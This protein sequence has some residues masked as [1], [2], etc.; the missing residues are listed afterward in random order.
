MVVGEVRDVTSNARGKGA[1]Q[2]SRDVTDSAEG[3]GSLGRDMFLITVQEGN[4]SL[5][6]CYRQCK[7]ARVVR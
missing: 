4:L 1:V 2:G 5:G 3:K 6:R 7:G